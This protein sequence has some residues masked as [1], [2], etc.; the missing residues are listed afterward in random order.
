MVGATSRIAVLRDEVGLCRSSRRP[1]QMS[2]SASA[3]LPV[4]MG[5]SE[6]NFR[7]SLRPSG[8]DLSQKAQETIPSKFYLSLKDQNL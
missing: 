5:A 2:R 1:F 8:T 7:F 6:D 3:G 4:S